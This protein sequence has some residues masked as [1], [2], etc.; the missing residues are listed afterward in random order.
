MVIEMLDRSLSVSEARKELDA[1]LKKLKGVVSFLEYKKRMR[2]FYLHDALKLRPNYAKD[3]ELVKEFFQFLKALEKGGLFTDIIKRG[4]LT[5]GTT[6]QR[7]LYHRF[8]RLIGVACSIPETPPKRGHRWIPLIINKRG[9]PEKYVEVPLKINRVSD[10]KTILDQLESLKG[11]KMSKWTKRFGSIPKLK[12]FMYLLGALV[13]DGSFGRVIGISTRT[14]ISLSTK[15]PWSETFGD[16]FCYCLGIFG[17][18]ANRT[19][20]S[21]FKNKEGQD[22]EK[23]NWSSSASP[24]LLW[25]RNSLLGL[26]TDAPKNEQS[27]QADWISQIPQDLIVPFLQGVADGDGYA[28]VRSLNAGIG[29]KHN[30][31]FFKLLLSIFHIDTRDGGTGLEITRKNSLRNAAELP[32]FRCA[33]GRQFRLNTIIEMIASMKWTKVSDEERDKILEYHRR[34]I[35]ANQIVPLLWSEFGKTRRSGTI[36]KVIKDFG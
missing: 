12:A 30:K 15:Y 8:P 25:M 29:T 19:K 2:S 18:N 31:D 36:Q 33:N 32:L 1:I 13:S 4:E 27:I 9:T 24:F 20:N 5:M 23:M 11:R 35:I 10:L 22:I 34:G 28:S 6:K 17:I 21:T 3:Y 7:R 14:S 16:A 26:R